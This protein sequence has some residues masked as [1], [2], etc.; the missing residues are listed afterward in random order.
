M[1]DIAGAG[2]MGHPSVTE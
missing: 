2:Q 1:K